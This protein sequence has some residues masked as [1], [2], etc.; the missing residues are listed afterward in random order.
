MANRYGSLVMLIVFPLL[1]AARQQGAEQTIPVPKEP[2]TKAA[3]PKIDGIWV[4]ALDAQDHVTP[5]Y[6]FDSYSPGKKVVELELSGDSIHVSDPETNITSTGT[7][8]DGKQ[9]SF[10]LPV[11]NQS[12]GNIKPAVFSGSVSGNTMLGTM[13]FDNAFVHFKAVKLL[14]AWECS[15]H[16]NPAHIAMTEEDMRTLTTEHKCTGWHKIT[17]LDVMQ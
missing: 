3:D 7:A 14:S 12:T 8:R 16:K 17:A 10:S 4:L 1:L 5:S 6:K 11:K 9:I 13:K 2:G 15:N